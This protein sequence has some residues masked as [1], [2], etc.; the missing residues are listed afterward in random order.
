MALVLLLTVA[1]ALSSNSAQARI[2][3][4]LLTTLSVEKTGA[5][6]SD[7]NVSAAGGID[8]GSTCSSVYATGGSVVLSANDNPKA[9]F[10]GWAGCDTVV[11]N[12]CYVWLESSRTVTAGFAA[13]RKL[14]V[15]VSGGGQGLVQYASAGGNCNAGSSCTYF[16]KEGELVS[17]YA[18]PIPGSTFGGWGGACAG[19]QTTCAFTLSADAVVT[20]TFA[21][22]VPP[23]PAPAPTP[24]P[25]PA[26]PPAPPV[27]APS[28]GAPSPAPK[29]CTIT[30][31]SGNDVLT[32]T[33][34]R[35]V[36]CGLGGN[37]KLIARGG[38][39]VLL[40]GAG[41][42]VL[43]GG[44]GADRL[45]GGLGNDRLVGGTGADRLLG[46]Q[47]L[48]VLLARDRAQDRLDGGAGRDRAQIDRRQ[49]LRLRVESLI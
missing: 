20:A 34:A 36:I 6:A 18:E 10:T 15:S 31:T 22:A 44:A 32:G 11:A 2:P 47:G 43:H 29:G 30:G 9:A 25:A 7:G 12:F 42:D 38:D 8:C 37:D 1:A 4:P 33:P 46:E 24:P 48:D 26:P 27:P 40:G 45:L 41:A 23:A 28:P 19:T 39:D 49:D 14:S 17:L 5:G 35:D 16:A 3:S 21:L 13:K